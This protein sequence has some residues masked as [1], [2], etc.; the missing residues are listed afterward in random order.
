VKYVEVSNG[1]EAV[2]AALNRVFDIILMDLHMPEMNGIEAAK[3]ILGA[4]PDARIVAVSATS[5]LP[6]QMAA[7]N[8][9]MYRFI[10][11]PF[12]ERD[13]FEMLIALVPS[14]TTAEDQRGSLVDTAALISLANGDSQ[15]LESMVR[16]FI[17]LT[18]SAVV[19]MEE[20]LEREETDSIA[21]EAHKMVASCV[22]IGA[23]NLAV[24]IRQ[25]EERV[26]QDDGAGLVRPAFQLVKE[27]AARVISFLQLHLDETGSAS[28]PVSSS[29]I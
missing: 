27:E 4:T 8:A 2:R 9:G 13:L 28:A 14:G 23:A 15:Y 18:G 16:L 12:I 1:K 10:S 22:Q 26:K 25:L 7:K 3:A 21:E 17:R 20:A 24:L 29:T 11:K 5:S 19:R 6:E